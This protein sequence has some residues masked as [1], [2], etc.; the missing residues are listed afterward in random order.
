MTIDYTIRVSDVVVLGGGVAAFLKVWVGSR[1]IQRDLTRLVN[2]HEARITKLRGDTDDHH[3]W[4]VRN[5][6][7]R[8][9]HQR[10]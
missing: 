2:D 7:D 9:A 3:E 6:L 4:L 5:G 10:G 1:D 8:R